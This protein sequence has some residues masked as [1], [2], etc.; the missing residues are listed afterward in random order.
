MKH[1]QKPSQG[2]RCAHSRGFTLIELLVVI[3]IIG[4]LAS[5]IL[6]SVN[7]ARRKARDTKRLADMNQMAKALELYFNEKNGYPAGTNILLDTVP[8]LTPTFVAKLPVAPT[9][10]DNPAN[11]TVCSTAGTCG[12]NPGNSYCYQAAGAAYTIAFCLG[13]TTGGIQSG[14]RYLTPG[15]FR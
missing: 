13:E 4:L 8:G 10:I 5:V 12:T 11:S 3:S 1:I 9:P 2:A 7:S 15:G 14:V 6:V